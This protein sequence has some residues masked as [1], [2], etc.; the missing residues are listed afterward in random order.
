MTLCTFPNLPEL[1]IIFL[2]ILIEMEQEERQ[3][4]WQLKREELEME[5]A[6]AEM[7]LADAQQEEEL[8]RTADESGLRDVLWKAL[9]KHHG[10]AEDGGEE[11]LVPA[12]GSGVVA[13]ESR[14]RVCMPSQL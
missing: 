3:L 14:C 6:E 8:K 4:K 12:M 11:P 2:W 1:T 5:L 9:M 7:E 10:D 13:A